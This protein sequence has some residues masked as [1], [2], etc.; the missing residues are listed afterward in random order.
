[1]LNINKKKT[2]VKYALWVIIEQIY[3]FI[4]YLSCVIL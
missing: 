3:K 1:M 2:E 4:I